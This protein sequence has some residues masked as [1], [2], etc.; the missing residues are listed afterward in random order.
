[1]LQA[2]VKFASMWPPRPTLHAMLVDHRL[3]LILC[4]LDL[5]SKFLIS[6]FGQPCQNKKYGNSVS[7][8]SL[9][10]ECAAQK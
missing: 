5:I 10:V 8:S 7:I 1:M 4:V 6:Y 9:T 2:L 3:L